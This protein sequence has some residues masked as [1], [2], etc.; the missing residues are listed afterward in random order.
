MD[1]RISRLRLLLLA[2]VIFTA[3]LSTAATETDQIDATSLKQ[4]LSAMGYTL[5]D[6]TAEKFEFT[7]KTSELEIPI[8]AEVS[9]SKNFIWLTV[10]LGKN[11]PTLNYEELLKQN[12]IIQPCFFYITGKENFMMGVAMENRGLTPAV[13]RR[14][15]E[16]LSRDVQSTRPVWDVP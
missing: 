6:L 14:I 1:A 16:K 11:K 4:M 5:T 13:V 10:F 3:P 7:L 12:F 9:S 15:V 2:A 8:A